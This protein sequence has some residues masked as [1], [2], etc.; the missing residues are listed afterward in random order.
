MQ[1]GATEASNWIDA[2]GV[3]VNFMGSLGTV[4]IAYAAYRFPIRQQRRKLADRVRDE[5]DSWRERLNEAFSDYRSG[6]VVQVDELRFPNLATLERSGIS[7]CTLNSAVKAL[8][9]QLR[10]NHPWG[11]SW[12]EGV[13]DGEETAGEVIEGV[14]NSSLDMVKDYVLEDGDFDHIAESF[15]YPTYFHSKLIE[16]D[17]DSNNTASQFAM[18]VQRN[19]SRYVNQA[20][21]SYIVDSPESDAVCRIEMLIHYK[22]L[23]ETSCM[24]A[25]FAND[26]VNYSPEKLSLISKMFVAEEGVIA[27]LR[28]YVDRQ[29]QIAELEFVKRGKI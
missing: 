26:V 5:Y 7:V 4:G 6:K 25:Y 29:Y 21:S 12:F 23:L 1:M 24:F 14:V 20:R 27:R 16:Y 3:A 9:A 10:F 15:W 8:E 11:R 2:M 22:L 18:D 13:F 19:L 28:D 17:K